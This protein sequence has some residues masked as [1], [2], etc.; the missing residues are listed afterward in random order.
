LLEKP[1]R[2]SV[3]FLEQVALPFHQGLARHFESAKQ[4]MEAE[5]FFLRANLAR[6][7]VEMYIRANKWEAAHKVSHQLFSPVQF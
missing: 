4:Y 3:F 6:E 2:N 7:A 1:N 5:K